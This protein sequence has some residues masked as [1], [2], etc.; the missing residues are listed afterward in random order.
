MDDGTLSSIY[1]KDLNGDSLTV[2]T[3]ELVERLGIVLE[4]ETPQEE[5]P[6][7]R[8]FLW[9]IQRKRNK[10][11]RS[12]VVAWSGRYGTRGSRVF[13]ANGN[14]RRMQMNDHCSPVWEN[15]VAG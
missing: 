7:Q 12:Y 2:L 10:G 11:S 13:P 1:A 14:P 3:P 5:E 9:H 15:H 4:I 8:F 6:E